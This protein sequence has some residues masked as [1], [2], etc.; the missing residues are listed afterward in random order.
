MA[1]GG[2]GGGS[3]GDGA[4][5]PEF[6]GQARFVLVDRLLSL[7]DRV[8]E[9]KVPHWVAIEAPTGWG[10]SRIVHEFYKRLA[11]DRQLDG[12]Y[13]SPSIGDDDQSTT[14]RRKR[15]TP[16]R[17]LEP[18]AKPSWM[19][20][21]IECGVLNGAPID[22]LAHRLGQFE[23]TKVDIER[24]WQSDQTASERLTQAVRARRGEVLEAGIGEAVAAGLSAVNIAVPGLGSLLLLLGKWGMQRGRREFGERGLAEDEESAQVPFAI[25]AAIGIGVLSSD[26]IPVVVFV[27]DLQESDADLVECLA[28]LLSVP[29]ARVLLVTTGW[30][31]HLVDTGRRSSQLAARVSEAQ[32]SVW[33]I[34]GTGDVVLDSLKPDDIGRIVQSTSALPS[35][36]VNVLSHRYQNPLAVQ[37]AS[38]AGTLRDAID[39]GRDAVAAASQLPVEVDD[40][41]RDAFR[42]LNSEVQTACMLAALACPAG[43][44][45]DS[46]YR[47]ARWDQELIAHAVESVAWIRRKVPD[48]D[49]A[50]RPGGG[51]YDWVREVETWLRRFHEQ[52]QLEV[53]RERALATDLRSPS[54]RE[55]YFAALLSRVRFDL[56]DSDE[57]TLNHALLVIALE[58]EGFIEKEDIWKS[59]VVYYCNFLRGS[60]TVEASAEI[61]SLMTRLGFDEP[62]IEQAQ[63]VA[64]IDDDEFLKI[65]AVLSGVDIDEMYIDEVSE[66]DR[67]GWQELRADLSNPTTLV[68]I[69]VGQITEEMRAGTTLFC[70]IRAEALVRLGW[71]NVALLQVLGTMMMLGPHLLERPRVPPK[72]DLDAA[73][74]N[75]VGFSAWVAGNAG[76]PALAADLLDFVIEAKEAAYGRGDPSTLSDRH[77]RARWRNK[78][79][80]DPAAQIAELREV[81]ALQMATGSDSRDVF[82][83][84]SNLASALAQLG[85]HEEA[86]A[87]NEAL[88]HDLL[89]SPERFSEVEVT[90]RS[91]L[92]AQTGYAGNPRKAV[93][94][95]RELLDGMEDSAGANAMKAWA[96]LRYWLHEV[97]DV[98]GAL[99]ANEHVIEI[100]RR[101]GGQSALDAELRLLALRLAKQWAY[102]LQDEGELELADTAFRQAIEATEL[103]RTARFNPLPV[104]DVNVGRLLAQR[105]AIARDLR[106]DLA[107]AIE[108][109]EQAISLEERGISSDASAYDLTSLSHV[110]HT[111]GLARHA[112]GDVAGALEGFLRAWETR[113][114]VLQCEPGDSAAQTYVRDKSVRLGLMAH[115]LGVAD[116]RSASWN[117]AESHLRSA[118]AMRE[119]VVAHDASALRLAD[120]ATSLGASD[121]R[122][123]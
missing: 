45:S 44:S 77:N 113:Q 105:A 62:N 79:D 81:R 103:A 28:S 70:K 15:V 99:A 6:V 110:L 24:R 118:V 122:V 11:A 32:R 58:A 33:S 91:N 57:R 27:E 21:G 104:D 63:E 117:D 107:T 7:Y 46:G 38:Q 101:R 10:K 97:G 71:A 37:L 86:R 92:A 35:A 89:G 115:R 19:W 42:R 40:L 30:T 3:G 18:S 29:G 123:E 4:R 98:H 36:V 78:A 34:S 13:W 96:N 60:G 43:V 1:G 100:L 53:V 94:L 119:F 49:E 23:E 55:E 66:D 121:L 120:L 8:L 108:L 51:A 109:F 47:D 68:E 5:E 69:G 93:E 9:E 39:E 88:L 59:A 12:Q 25:S 72:G 114:R 87:A 31:G 73:W 90:V 48:F 54:H 52:A 17:G 65:V 112:S 14:A 95:Y 50:L 22:A 64:G 76:R 26:V 82:V 80:P 20:W 56:A 67:E 41:Y 83:T 16:T 116:A 75:L 74:I 61:V 2:G 106:G 85:R 102:E 111:L 84:R